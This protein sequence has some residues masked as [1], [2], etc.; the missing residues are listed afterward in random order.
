MYGLMTYN[1]GWR[2]SWNL[3]FKIALVL[4]LPSS[5]NDS[6]QMPL[7]Q[8][9]IL[10]CHSVHMSA[11]FLIQTKVMWARVMCK[12]DMWANQVTFGIK[13]LKSGILSTT[14]LS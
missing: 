1:M 10:K 13:F 7:P 8:N 4:S 3:I 11:S 14:I 9:F 5:Q 6:A 12:A 2:E